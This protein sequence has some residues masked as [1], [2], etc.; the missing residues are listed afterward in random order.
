MSNDAIN[1]LCFEY[2]TYIIISVGWNIFDA[3]NFFMKN[4][5]M[6][7]NKNILFLLVV[8]ASVQEN[9]FSAPVESS[10]VWISFGHITF[11][12][13]DC[14]WGKITGKKQ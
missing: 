10:Q 14:K 2:K 6:I 5:I 12:N 9:E 7:Y 8:K 1:K 4:I 13:A 3:K 11:P